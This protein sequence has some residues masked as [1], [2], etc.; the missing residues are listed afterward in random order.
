MRSFAL[1]LALFAAGSAQ[2]ASPIFIDNESGG[3]LRAKMKT[4]G[5]VKYGVMTERDYPHEALEREQTGRV[6]VSFNI[7]ANGRASDCQIARSSGVPVLDA[8][9][10]LIVNTRY[11]VE[12]PRDEDG[13]PILGMARQYVTWQLAD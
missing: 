11:V 7:A 12:P 3:E 6:L 13:N 9:T 2:A 5:Y 8:R 1:T 10:C 4:M